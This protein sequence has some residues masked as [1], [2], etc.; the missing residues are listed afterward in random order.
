MKTTQM[1]AFIREKE[2]VTQRWDRRLAGWFFLFIFGLQV[3][4]GESI[5]PLASK[6]Q[7]AKE[8]F[9]GSDVVAV[10]VTVW[11]LLVTLYLWDDKG[12]TRLTNF[13]LRRK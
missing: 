1:P 5:Y 6:Y 10:V 8:A 7:W 11:P 4:E 13:F 2:I 12:L 9:G 3:A